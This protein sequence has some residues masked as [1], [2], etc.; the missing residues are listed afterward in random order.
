MLPNCLVADHFMSRM[1]PNVSCEWCTHCASCGKQNLALW[2]SAFLIVNWAF[3]IGF[4]PRP[5]LLADKIFLYGI[6]PAFSFIIPPM[7]IYDWPR[8]RTVI[9]Q[10]IL[11][12]SVWIWSLYQV[13]FM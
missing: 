10:V 3:G 4:V 5:L 9:Y 7:V 11:V 13:I 8:D 2:S 6:A 1:L 12:I